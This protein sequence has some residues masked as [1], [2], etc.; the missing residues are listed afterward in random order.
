MCAGVLAFL[1]LVPL[2]T[3]C[4]G[5]S[6]GPESGSTK[7]PVL[8]PDEIGIEV[9]SGSPV[10]AEKIKVTPIK[11]DS[12]KLLPSVS[13]G[14]EILSA[15]HFEVEADVSRF[16]EGVKVSFPLS[17]KQPAGTKLWIVVLDESSR[18]W[19]GIGERAVVTASGNRA[20]GTV[21]HFSTVAASTKN[22]DLPAPS[23]KPV[24][25]N[26]DG[27]FSSEPEDPEAERLV[28]R[29]RFAGYQPK[30]VGKDSRNKVLEVYKTMEGRAMTSADFQ[31]LVASGDYATIKTL[32]EEGKISAE[33]NRALGDWR[34]FHLVDSIMDFCR[35]NPGVKFYRSDT[36]NQK[37]AY[38]SDVDQT[39]FAY[40]YNETT[41]QWDRWPEGDSLVKE[42]CHSRLENMGI[43]VG[44]M[45]VETMPGAD[46]FI[47][48]RLLSVEI[49]KAVQAEQRGGDR[50]VVIRFANVAL[51]M[52]PGAYF[53]AGSV[54][55]QQQ[56]RV[57]DQASLHLRRAGST[58]DAPPPDDRA[59]EV[60]ET[61][62]LL[63]RLNGQVCTEIGPPDD[64]PRGEVG[65]REGTFEDAT[66]VLMDGIEPELQRGWGYD[67][68]VDNWFKYMEKVKYALD[69]GKAPPAKYLLRLVNNGPGLIAHLDGKMGYVEYEKI[70]EAKRKQFLIHCFGAD[71]DNA[72][73]IRSNTSML[74][75]WK[76]AMDIS[77][78]I[79]NIS[80]V[81]KRPV[82]QADLDRAFEPLAKQMAGPGNEGRWREFLGQARKRYNAHAQA[83]MA[84]SIIQ[85]SKERVLGWLTADPNTRNSEDLRKHID[86][87]EIRRALGMEGADFDG[88]WNKI[89][90]EIFRNYADTARAQL[91]FSFRMMPRD[92]VE[93]IV[94]QAARNKKLSDADVNRLVDLAAESMHWTFHYHRYREFPSLY[95]ALIGRWSRYQLG[96]IGK[97]IKDWALTDLGWIDTGGGPRIRNPMLG[98][99]GL[100]GMDEAFTEFFK[101]YNRTAGFGAR[102][103]R[104]M[105]WDIGNMDGIA[106]VLQAT[107][108][109]NGNPEA[110]ALA[111]IR[112][113]AYAVPVL[114][115]VLS[116]AQV[117]SVGEAAQT[118]TLLGCAMY[119]PAGRYAMVIFSIGDAGVSIYHSDYRVPLSNAIADAVY[120]GYTGPSLY[121]YG[122]QPAEYT[123]EDMKR[124]Y[125]VW[126]LIKAM[127][128]TGSNES[129]LMG[130]L[131]EEQ[132]LDWKKAQWNGFINE[133]SRNEGGWF[134]GSGAQLRQHGINFPSPA[135]EFES[136][137]EYKSGPI[138]AQVKPMIMFTSSKL[139]PVEFYLPPLT[140]EQ[141]ARKK[142]LDDLVKTE[143]HPI[144][145]YEIAEELEK[146][147]V[148]YEA[149]KRAQD[150]LE[151]A[152]VNLDMR[153]QI[154][155]DSLWPF[156]ETKEGL[157]L[158]GTKR[159]VSDWFL[160]RREKLGEWLGQYNIKS[161]WESIKEA[162]EQ[163]SERM[164][165]DIERSKERW[166]QFKKFKEGR[167]K[168]TAQW[169]EQ[170]KIRAHVEAMMMAVEDKV[171]RLSEDTIATLK[172]SGVD[173]NFAYACEY[174]SEAIANR[175]RP[176]S[177]PQV[178]ITGRIVKGDPEAEE[179]N[180]R[181]HQLYP[182]V[183]VVADP[184]VYIQP[185]SYV[186]Y[187]LNHEA[188]RKALGG[189][190]RG[191]PVDD[192]MKKGLQQYLEYVDEPEND[193]ELRPPAFL[194]YAFCTDFKL[195]DRVVK[196]TSDRLPRLKQ[197]TIPGQEA[198]AYVLGG[199]ALWEDLDPVLPPGPVQIK[200]RRGRPRLHRTEIVVTSENLP[201][202]DNQDKD[203]QLIY[204]VE[205]ALDRDGPWQ[206]LFGERYYKPGREIVED[207]PAKKKERGYRIAEDT[208]VI[209]DNDI[210]TVYREQNWPQNKM[211]YIRVAE[212]WRTGYGEDDLS[213]KT[214]SNIAG[215]KAGI[216]TWDVSTSLLKDRKKKYEPDTPEI[217]LSGPR[218]DMQMNVYFGPANMFLTFP[219]AHLTLNDGERTRHFWMSRQVGKMSYGGGTSSSP[220]SSRVSL[221]ATL[222]GKE[223][224]LQFAGDCE[225][226][227]AKG[228]LKVLVDTSPEDQQKREEWFTQLKE[229][230][231]EKIAQL[232]AKDKEDEYR[233]ADCK[234]RVAN[235]TAKIEKLK[236]E[237]PQPTGD[238]RMWEKQ[239]LI[240]QRDMVEA[241]YKLKMR[242]ECDLPFEKG[243]YGRK[244]GLYHYQYVAANKHTGTMLQ[245]E[246]KRGK[247]LKERATK[248]MAINDKIYGYSDDAEWTRNKRESNKRRY[249]A[250]IKRAE[251]HLALFMSGVSAFTNIG[252]AVCNDAYLGGDAAGL[253]ERYQLRIDGQKYA[254]ENTETTSDQNSIKRKIGE[255]MMEYADLAVQLTGNR[256][257]AASVY[258]R[259]WILKQ[260]ART[261]NQESWGDLKYLPSWWPPGSGD[262]AYE[263][264]P[265]KPKPKKNPDD[266][267]EPES[268]TGE[269]PDAPA[270]K[271]GTDDAEA[272]N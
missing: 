74:D 136:E 90:S 253:K 258:K 193:E 30:V 164:L 245:A 181:Q 80:A 153:H 233:F 188:A 212:Q 23:G 163:I 25:I 112:E 24:A 55:Q 73:G 171:N 138:L 167:E 92:T 161:D 31:K 107:S 241:E 140:A 238:I 118:A 3:G 127:R 27:R 134:T 249:T 85:T 32:I 58:S 246:G 114:G 267:D 169:Y 239:R 63:G 21:Y 56:L 106:R 157:P 155:M 130:L 120:R 168:K 182:S 61:K 226:A 50:G 165:K 133:Q 44:K 115:Q 263:P 33:H 179:E 36:G 53:L 15:A 208:V 190:Y 98:R 12:L 100:V 203:T 62:D 60:A 154:R 41:G 261:E 257:Q 96:T 218:R 72:R 17:V 113:T 126:A 40:K 111:M 205:S 131:V 47:D 10:P 89:R 57:A 84:H 13:E 65:V 254:F 191:L 229:K 81:E 48:E 195:P 176:V 224:A 141:L 214:Y 102:F 77:A 67:A 174:L 66:R 123:S 147:T 215:P 222:H 39:L 234:K 256:Q 135:P 160:V 1:F 137:P 19:Y 139:G 269:D 6:K 271:P 43:G 7:K 91:M 220:R 272:Q 75:D 230:H 129:E 265:P 199:A 211:C 70:P 178:K 82:T 101:K 54:K 173:I 116:F 207:D 242:K 166:E 228:T 26:P 252:E 201:K 223:T 52:Q 148:H 103:V 183:K 125:E 216:I 266:P 93:L 146:L 20:E 221:S 162:R 42:H 149:W 244:V 122:G 251:S 260:Q 9:A 128:Y 259:G 35:K 243:A 235:I 108:E 37:N 209:D 156:M 51:G 232:K 22:A 189:D 105:V 213:K 196:K 180:D 97:R 88:K 184:L 86:E 68:S 76:M 248:L 34:I 185:Y 18:T 150:Y 28:P 159:Y 240:L 231:T 8:G 204:T 29:V 78:E 227:S 99:L 69:P 95:H 237:K 219:G 236:K 132:K 109:S 94:E 121:N 124:H 46:R 197:V 202:L 4:G 198:K 187:Q 255:L 172:E 45:E 170:A 104:N 217:E 117:R 200:L 49:D 59:I 38:L 210:E 247:F 144:E 186:V 119:T 11:G 225:D 264:P 79:R 16:P 143:T 14:A 270:S 192:M 151:R 145:Q 175:H 87:N 2:L 206:K 5:D 268:E 152:K 142:E 262:R 177:A 110:V 158:V 83:I 64:N 250:Q 71:I 194:V